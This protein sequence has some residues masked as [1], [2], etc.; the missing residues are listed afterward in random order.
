MKQQKIGLL[1]VGVIAV[2]LFITHVSSGTASASLLDNLKNFFKSTPD[3]SAVT[4]S[5]PPVTPYAPTIDYEDAVIRAV[6]VG[7]KSVVSI[8]I[9]KDLPVIERCAYNPW[10][11]LPPEFRD[12]FGGDSFNQFSRPCDNGKT[13]NKQIGGGSGFVVSEDGLILTNKHVVEDEKADYTV[14]TNDG[15]KHKAQVLARDPIQ[16]LAIIKIN[17][18]GLPVAKLG[19]SSS[20]R[21][22]QTAIAIGNALGEFSN[23]VSVGVVSG[24]SRS[25]TA[26]SGMGSSEDL[27]N[28]IQTDAAI[29]PGNSGGPLL[30][31]KGEVIGINT[32]IVSGAQSIGFAIPI[33]QAKR[34][35]SS[36]KKTGTIKASYLGVRY[37]V[38]TDDVVKKQNLSVT[39]GALVR[40]TV[41]GPAVAPGSPAD[42]AGIKAE[43]IITEI[44][45]KKVT[46]DNVLVDLIQEYSI[47]DTI[48]LTIQRGK[49]VIHL[50]VTLTERPGSDR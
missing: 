28:L 31:L 6:E 46:K 34:D 19:D 38:I 9:S 23:T 17:K 27:K 22:G 50:K 14:I 18:T 35:I 41:D 13:E 44:N 49:E 26:S 8:V 33:N 1:A 29:N 45:G 24:L 10:S 20:L 43:D 30:N 5:A 42:K 25:V 47:G 40:G 21:L 39:E 12:F 48:D 2:F 37:L 7:S 32:A 36:V 16:D 4:P 11:N 15:E 3:N